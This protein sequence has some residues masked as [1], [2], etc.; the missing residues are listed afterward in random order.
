MQHSSA[1]LGLVPMT[2]EMWLELE[3]IKH[4]C[5]VQLAA[6]RQFP[7]EMH[8]VALL[9][10]WPYV[11]L[12]EIVSRSPSVVL[13]PR[14]G[15]WGINFFRFGYFGERCILQPAVL[16]ALHWNLSV[17]CRTRAGW[18]RT[19]SLPLQAQCRQPFEAAVGQHSVAG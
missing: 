19:C 2:P 11:L 7:R 1:V 6:V 16:K 15:G 8:G 4:R 5:H 10:Q 14:L 12:W 13:V 9:L 17:W 18:W 3:P